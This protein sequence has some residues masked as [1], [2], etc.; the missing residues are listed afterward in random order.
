MKATIIK[1]RDSICTIDE[2]SEEVQRKVRFFLGSSVGII[3]GMNK[4]ADEKFLNRECEVYD[5]SGFK[6]WYWKGIVLKRK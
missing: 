3:P 1:T 2:Y 6:M 5:F 4:I